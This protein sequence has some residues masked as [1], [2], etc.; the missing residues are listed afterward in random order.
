MNLPIVQFL[1][2][3]SNIE[4]SKIFEKSYPYK[5]MDE[6]QKNSLCQAW[7]LLKYKFYILFLQLIIFLS[8]YHKT[9]SLLWFDPAPSILE[10]IEHFYVRKY[11]PD[12]MFWDLLKDLF[13]IAKLSVWTC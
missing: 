8:I 9:G 7:K 1:L 6:D 2:N 5:P 12:K 10:H 3:L 11:G 13:A 4:I